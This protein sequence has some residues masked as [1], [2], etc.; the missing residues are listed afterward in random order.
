M[1]WK[2]RLGLRI[3]FWIGCFLLSDSKVSSEM[4]DDLKRFQTALNVTGKKDTF[5]DE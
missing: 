3:L 1:N 5:G 4:Q 2:E